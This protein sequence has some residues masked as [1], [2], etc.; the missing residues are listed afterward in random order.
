MLAS[1]ARERQAG[2][3]RVRVIRV[4]D[5]TSE[6]SR[7]RTVVLDSAGSAVFSLNAIGSLV[8]EALPGDLDEIVDSICGRF[9]A[10]P[11][12]QVESDVASFLSELSERELVEFD[13]DT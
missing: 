2:R 13:A 9:P 3:N 7:E 8:W 1:S 11:R 5:V 10:V 6:R 4:D 12:K